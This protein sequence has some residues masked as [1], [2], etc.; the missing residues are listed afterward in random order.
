MIEINLIYFT[1]LSTIALQQTKTNL[2]CSFISYC[3]TPLR[4]IGTLPSTTMFWKTRIHGL[5]S[6]SLVTYA[7]PQHVVEHSLNLSLHIWNSDV[8]FIQFIRLLQHL[9]R[10]CA[11]PEMPRTSLIPHA[12]DYIG[13]P[14]VRKLMMPGHAGPK[15]CMR[16]PVVVM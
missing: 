12:C 2:H 13:L 11:E 9:S 6:Q 8:L 16:Q 3:Q 1:S 14:S 4:F 7:W 5:I 15:P 10:I